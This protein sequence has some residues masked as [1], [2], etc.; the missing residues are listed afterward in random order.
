MPFGMSNAPATFQATMNQLLQ[1][2]LRKFVI[3]FFDDILVYKVSW[4]LHIELLATVFQLLW[5]HCFYVLESKCAFGLEELMYLGHIIS[6]QEIRPDPDK[7][8]VV[9]GWPHPTTVK[10]TQAFLGLTGYYRKFVAQYA[11]IAMPLTDLLRKDGFNWTP[12]ATEAFKKLKLVLITTPVLVFPNFDLPFVVE[13]D[14][15]EVS[16]GAVLLHRSIHCHT[17]VRSYRTCDSGP[18][19]TP[20][21]C[22]H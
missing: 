21:S 4:E 15:C 2:L 17:S 19:H 12:E 6:P 22:G 5:Q 11:Q 16:I 1:L 10:Q 13:T 8:E 14:A 7:V 3:V 9:L 20:K 18:Q